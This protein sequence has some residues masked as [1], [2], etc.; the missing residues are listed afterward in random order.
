M[1]LYFRLL[2]WIYDYFYRQALKQRL[3]SAEEM[4]AWRA[5]IASLK[6]KA[7]GK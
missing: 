1:R 4:W 3:M 7:E 6:E 2:H 5:R